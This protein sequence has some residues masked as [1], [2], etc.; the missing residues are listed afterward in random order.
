MSSEEQWGSSEAVISLRSV[1]GFEWWE[2]LND[3]R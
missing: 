3:G 2:D 1:L